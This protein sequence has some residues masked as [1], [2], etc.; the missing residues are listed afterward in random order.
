M[1]REVDSLIAYVK[2]INSDVVISATLGHFVSNSNPCS[3]HSPASNHC[4]AGTGGKGLAVDWGGTTKQIQNAYNALKLV[5]NKLSELIYNA[6][7]ITQAVKDGRWVSGVGFYGPTTWNNHKNHVHVAVNKGVFLTPVAPAPA[8]VPA[9]PPAGV[10]VPASYLTEVVQVP[11]TMYRSQ[12]GYAIVGGDGG[13]FNYDTPFFGSLGGVALNTPIV[14]GAW[15]PSGA[16][17]WLVS[18]DGAIFSFGDAPFRGGLNGTSHLGPRKIIG[19]VSKGNG[20][21]FVTLDPTNDGSPFDVYD[22]G[23]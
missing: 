4:A 14:A 6:P 21:R 17:Y 7:G 15:T 20:Y 8:P 10:T 23:V 3:P 1:S 12:G 11:F 19:F 13:V 5:P 22:L 2:S 16:G 9:P 18:S